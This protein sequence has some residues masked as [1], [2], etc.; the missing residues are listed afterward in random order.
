MSDALLPVRY[1]EM[2]RAINAAYEVDEVKDIRDKARAMEVY[3]RQA[4]NTEAERRACEIRLRA[5]R[6]A[7][8]LLAER[9]KN[10][11]G[12]EAGVGRAG[13]MRSDA[14]TTLSGLGISKQQSANWQR[15]AAVPEDE[16]E[17]ALADPDEKPTTNGIIGKPKP[18]P[19]EDDALWLW[20]R[21]LEFE[22]RGILTRPANGVLQTML[23]HMD[24]T[25]RELAPKVAEWLK[26][27][28]E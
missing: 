10:R 20:G 24:E 19:V 28:A 12:G 16:F 25:V 27:V 6:K 13:G 5:E 7:G 4:R 9:D 17:A 21:L 18:T 23:P 3:L 15:L 22:R 14:P 8:A 2:C 11:G 26:G 1:D